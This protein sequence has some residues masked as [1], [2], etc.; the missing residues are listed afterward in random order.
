MTERNRGYIV[1]LD[2]PERVDSADVLNAIRQLKGVASVEQIRGDVDQQ[3]AK[4]RAKQEL[5]DEL[6]EVLAS[7]HET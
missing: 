3:L 1:A 2:N 6:W 4:Q 7:D 5:I